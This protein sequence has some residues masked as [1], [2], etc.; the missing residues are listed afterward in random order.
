MADTKLTK[1]EEKISLEKL[2]KVFKQ[3]GFSIGKIS[4]IYIAPVYRPDYMKA[5]VGKCP[6]CQQWIG[7]NKAHICA[8]IVGESFPVKP[9]E[10]DQPEK[11]QMPLL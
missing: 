1:K 7:P 11:Q 10:M 5:P 4:H 6:Q 2:E 9:H 3:K 8:L